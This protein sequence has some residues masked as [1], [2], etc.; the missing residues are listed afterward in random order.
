MRHRRALR[1]RVTAAI[2][3]FAAAMPVA[4]AD[5]D[6]LRHIVQDQCLPRWAR[7]HEAAPCLRIEAQTF[8]LLAD[9]KGGAHLL[10]IPTRTVSGIED[11]SLLSPG[12][13]NYFAA[14][15]RA[16]A[17]LAPLA[18]HALRRESVG[19][20][21]NSAVARG[22]D[23]FHIHIECVGRE[24]ERAL[25][26]LSRRIGERWTRLP[27]AAWGFY[28]LRIGGADLERADPIR[29]LATLPGARA[30]MGRYTLLVVPMA[31]A[32]GP[33]F[34]ALAG[35]TAP[36]GDPLPRLMRGLVPPG[37][38]LLDSSCAIDP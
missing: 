3:V 7:S 10:L 17:E 36:R 29:L 32:E 25:R 33:G 20:A 28:A 18:G 34:V 11:P 26:A 31:F 27:R 4:A 9:R 24:L 30:R 2:A 16:R 15:W 1:A 38:R 22:Q 37:E 19:L 14:A 8:A 6:A 5:R 13:P 21:I 23:Q 35:P 12:A